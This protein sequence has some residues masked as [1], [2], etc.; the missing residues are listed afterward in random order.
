MRVCA[1]VGRGKGNPLACGKLMLALKF[2]AF[3]TDSCDFYASQPLRNESQPKRGEL[4]EREGKPRDERNGKANKTRKNNCNSDLWS[5]ENETV[6]A[7]LTLS[8]NL[9]QNFGQLRVGGKLWA[10]TTPPG[11]CLWHWGHISRMLPQNRLNAIWLNWANLLCSSAR[12]ADE[13]LCSIVVGLINLS[14]ASA[15]NTCRDDEFNRIN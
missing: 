5:D 4:R 1:C 12:V 3:W 6:C 8:S 2:L 14:A 10:D 15:T 11:C 9:P 7:G 13:N